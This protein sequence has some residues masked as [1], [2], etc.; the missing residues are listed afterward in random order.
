MT[1]AEFLNKYG[2][3]LV[4]FAS[5]YKYTFTFQG[6]NNP[7]LEVHT[8]GHSVDIYRYTVDTTP[9]AVA[10]LLPNYGECGED[11]FYDDGY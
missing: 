3:E 6:V 4:Q 9:I 7:A 2:Q 8:G 5:Y 1:Q 10:R 11:S